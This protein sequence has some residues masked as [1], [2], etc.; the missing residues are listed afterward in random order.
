MS[1][2]EFNCPHCNQTIE[3]P[4][5]MLGQLIDCPA[6]GGAI[7]LPPPEPPAE[8]PPEPLPEPPAELPPQI[9]APAPGRKKF[10]IRR[11]AGGPPLT[12]S[13]PGRAPAHAPAGQPRQAPKEYGGIGRG[14]YFLGMI[15]ANAVSLIAQVIGQSIVVQGA[16]GL[17]VIVILLGSIVALVVSFVLVVKRLNNVGMS[18]WWSLLLLVPIAN[19]IIGVRCLVCQEGYQDTKKLDTTGKVITGI[20]LGLFGLVVVGV[21]IAVIA[22]R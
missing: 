18:G 6:C 20:V 2:M 3:A 14:M 7:Q 12:R 4:E 21:L 8:P 22:S 10:I 1:D 11:P 15:G 9:E 17:G 13:L 19:L 16:R 5:D